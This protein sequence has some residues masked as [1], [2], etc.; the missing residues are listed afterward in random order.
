[1]FALQGA[2]AH[3]DVWNRVENAISGS[4]QV[5]GIS[6]TRLA[7]HVVETRDLIFFAIPGAF[8]PVRKRLPIGEAI[9]PQPIRD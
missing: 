2:D 1:L 9:S 5:L 8:M 7:T 6:H 4:T 3:I